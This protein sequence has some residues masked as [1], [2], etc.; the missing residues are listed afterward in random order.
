M[1]SFSL[2]FK[3]ESHTYLSNIGLLFTD[4]IS[5]PP[6]VLSGMVNIESKIKIKTTKQ[7]DNQIK[8]GIDLIKISITSKIMMLCFCLAYH[9]SS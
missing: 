9:K 4:S 7:K 3:Y 1:S 5:F 6:K 8:R 2:K